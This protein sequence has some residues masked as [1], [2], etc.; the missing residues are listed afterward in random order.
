MRCRTA[1]TLM[2]AASDGELSS[3]E[4]R[5]LDRHLTR[6]AACR[7]E[8]VST[9]GALAALRTLPLEGTV[10]ATLEARVLRAVAQ[11]R[12]EEARHGVWARLRDSIGGL[13]PVLAAGAVAVLALVSVRSVDVG[14]IVP[15]TARTPDRSVARSTPERPLVAR[16]SKTMPVDP[17]AALAARPDLFVDLPIL[18]NLDK[19][20]H[21]DAIATMDDDPSDGPPPS[22]G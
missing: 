3:R 8:R 20:Q 19:L 12:A 6:C 11:I 2:I 9:E 15:G 14:P 22:N 5:A 7:A 1:A 16:R 10:P 4:R 17:P 21:F 18:R 13:A